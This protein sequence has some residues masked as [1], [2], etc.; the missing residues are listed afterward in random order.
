[1]FAKVKKVLTIIVL[2]ILLIILFIS[3]TILINS[4]IHPDEVPSFFG[5]KPFIV[6]SRKYA[7][8]DR[9]TEI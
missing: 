7:S 1:M 6:L 5:W 4:Y 9:S 3:G 8:R 2:I